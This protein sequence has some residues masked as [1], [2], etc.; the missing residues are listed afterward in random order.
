MITAPEKLMGK[1]ICLFSH[2]SNTI[3]SYEICKVKNSFF[4][5]MIEVKELIGDN[6]RFTYFIEKPL[7]EGNEFLFIILKNSKVYLNKYILVYDALKSYKVMND[8]K[9]KVLK[10]DKSETIYFN[11][12]KSMERNMLVFDLFDKKEIIPICYLDT[13]I[14]QL[15]GKFLLK[16]NRNYLMIQMH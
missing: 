16:P 14:N 7:P 15:R 12:L 11:Y 13:K 6:N 3:F 4:K 5:K 2:V 8:I 10:T 9:Y 1:Y